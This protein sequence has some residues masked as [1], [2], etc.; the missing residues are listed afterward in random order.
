MRIV[1]LSDT[2]CQTKAL[3]RCLTISAPLLKNADKI[4]HLGDGIENSLPFLADYRKINFIKGSHD[5]G[6]GAESLALEQKIQGVN[7]LFTHGDRNDKIQ[8]QLNIWGN[9]LRWELFKAPPNFDDYYKQL[10]QRCQDRHHLVVHG[11]LHIPKIKKVRKTIF[12]CPGGIS[13]TVFGHQPSLGL[14]ILKKI[15]LKTTS[16]KCFSYTIDL[17]KNKLILNLRKN[18]YVGPG[19]IRT[20]I[21]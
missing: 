10:Y 18:Y 3:G 7:F 12:F 19:G 4:I 9:K 5:K 17:D 15:N 2:H 1:L 11:H 16:I 13:K 21:K 6:S 14:I 8:E 20:S